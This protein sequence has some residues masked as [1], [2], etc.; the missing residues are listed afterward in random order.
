MEFHITMAVSPAEIGAIEDAILAIDPSV[1]VDIDPSG[2]ALRVAASVD[3]AQLVTLMG[4]AGFAVAPHQVA[5][6]PSICCGGCSG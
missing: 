6:V 4:Q 2:R 5:Q 3:V 1:L